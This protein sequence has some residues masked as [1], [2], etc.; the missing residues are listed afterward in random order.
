MCVF[1]CVLCLG[2]CVFYVRVFAF[3][4]VCVCVCFYVRVFALVCVCV[5]LFVFYVRVFAFVCVCVC[6][7]VCKR[8]REREREREKQYCATS[9]QLHAYAN[10]IRA[11]GHDGMHFFS[12]LMIPNWDSPQNSTILIIRVPPLA[13][14]DCTRISSRYL[15]YTILL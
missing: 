9:V 6:V 11:S 10:A 2:V 14:L 15:T 7:C 8:E 3:V 1:V 4:C 5:C 12:L 13:S